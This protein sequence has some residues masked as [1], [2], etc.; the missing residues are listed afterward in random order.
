MESKR[1][2][3]RALEEY[4]LK[5][6]ESKRESQKIRERY[7][8]W[9]SKEKKKLLKKIS[10]LERRKPP[11]NVDERLLQ[12]VEAERRAYVSALR[13]IIEGIENME[14][15]GKRLPDLAKLHV[16][17]GRHVTILYEKDVYAI[18]S[19]LK[20]MSE[21]YSRYLE[22]LEAV[23]V[24][25]LRVEE[26]LKQIEEV[27]RRIEEIS[28]DLN[29]LEGQV[30]EKKALLEKAM[31]SDELSSIERRIEDRKREIRRKEIEVR[32]R[33]SKLSKPLRRMRLGGIADEVSR[34][35]GV[36]IERSS[37]FLR[38]L[39]DVLPR[40]EGKARKSGEWLLKNLEGEVEELR[41]LREEL[42]SLE[43][44]RSR[45]MEELKPLE[46]ELRALE[47]RQKVLEDEK[48]RLENKL[49]HL[50]GELE[51]E[52]EELNRVIRG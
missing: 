49:S 4:R 9:L 3:Q 37:E 41:S 15:L 29:L 7:G 17:H 39:E 23:S 32:S 11:K 28:E 2:L 22:E 47:A 52:L 30:K 35:S 43:E 13:R 8:K 24:P 6:E 48:A 14:D 18:N 44:E 38:M 26:I 46:D 40:L 31:T 1:S 36:A 27:S 50:K 45:L 10:E 25:E 12:R 51:A 34:D 21:T 42:S 33:V 19:L 5:L 16:D 20:E